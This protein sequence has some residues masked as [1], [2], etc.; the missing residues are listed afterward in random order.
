MD[1]E[2]IISSVQD[3]LD[4]QLSGAMGHISQEPYKREFFA[5]FKEAYNGNYFDSSSSP[6]LTGDAFTDILAAR[7]VTGGE[8]KEKERGQL[9]ESLFTKWEEWRYAWDHY[10][11]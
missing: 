4:L 8:E 1:Q 6:R 7:W 10:S 3:K 11:D 5:L 9:M 2:E